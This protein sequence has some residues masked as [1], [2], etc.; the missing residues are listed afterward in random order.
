MYVETILLEITR[1]CTLYCEHCCRG[2]KEIINV[3]SLTID[4]IFKDIEYVDEI[5]LTG[6]EP[7]LAINELE[8]LANLIISGKIKVRTL[9]FITNATALC[10]RTLRILKSLREVVDLD[11][12]LSSDIFHELELERL[13]FLDKRNENVKILKELF[14]IKTHTSMELDKGGFKN[15]GLLYAGRAKNITA[16]RLDEI[17][18]MIPFNYIISKWFSGVVHKVK[19]EDDT[20]YGSIYIDVNGFLVR[21]DREE[22]ECEDEDEIEANININELPL[23]D[24]VIKFIEY[25]DRKH[26]EDVEKLLTIK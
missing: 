9:S 1:N 8:Y 6:G 24:A 15:R 16:E 13:G 21:S 5:F 4:N 22:F 14:S 11:I 17:N 25:K 7:L 26:E 2:D 19:I 10:S 12:R 18:A 23:R 3:S 20:I